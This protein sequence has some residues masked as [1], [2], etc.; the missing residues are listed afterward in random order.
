MRDMTDTA[1][2]ARTMS[3][4]ARSIGPEGTTRPEDLVVAEGLPLERLYAR[5]DAIARGRAHGDSSA[6][7]RS[8]IA[9][10]ESNQR[11]AEALG[12]SDFVLGRAGGSGRLE[13]RGTRP[14]GGTRELVPDAIPYDAAAPS[15]N[16]AAGDDSPHRPDGRI[17]TDLANIAWRSRMTWL[18]DGGR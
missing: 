17:G 5:F 18:D 2:A 4:H 7:H 13:L 3:T 11:R 12:W 6:A 16:A 8:V 14:S 9:R 1:S 15:T 10:L